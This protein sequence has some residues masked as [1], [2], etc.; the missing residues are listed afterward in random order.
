M[1]KFYA[2][3]FAAVAWMGFAACS[4]D[5]TTDEVAPEVE[6][7]QVTMVEFFAQADNVRTE[8]DD[9]Q[10][11]KW[12]KED[13]IS[14]FDGENKE[15]KVKDYTDPYNVSFEGEL[16]KGE[17]YMALYPHTA[18]ATA[19]VK[20]CT[21]SNV[22]VPAAQTLT[23]GTFAEG[24]AVAVAYTTDNTLSFKN[25]V[26][27]LKFQVA[28]ACETITITS[29]EPLAGTIDVTYDGQNEPTI[30]V[31]KAEYT[32]TLTGPFAAGQTYYA[33]VLPG[34]SNATYEVRFN[35]YLSTKKT[36]GKP[37]QRSVMMNMQSLPAPEQ[38][39]WYVIGGMNKWTLSDVNYKMYKDNNGILVLR[40][41]NVK[42]QS[43]QTAGFQFNK[44]S[45]SVQ[46]GAYATT[47][48]NFESIGWYGAT[49]NKDHKQNI[50]VNDTSVPYD[51]Y[52]NLY[53]G[54]TTG[55]SCNFIAVKSSY[56]S[57]PNQ[58]S[59]IGQVEGTDWNKDFTLVKTSNTTAELKNIQL[60][61]EF[62]VRL[63]SNWH[64]SWAKTGNGVTLSNGN[65]KVSTPGRYDVK[66][67]FSN[68]NNSTQVNTVTRVDV[69]KVD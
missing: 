28:T 2:Y 7:G 36:A 57:T 11:T 3:L 69:T 9:A 26:S 43:G 16:T 35:G 41:V 51:I 54:T 22:E 44:G 49:Y 32:L 67:T 31:K 21:I 65:M 4:E 66:V 5:A 10:K 52:L 62:K 40:N 39:D 29:D 18:T 56:N 37:R 1:K 64:T 14:L 59:L 68:K 38:S 25:V 8:L 45:W 48:N 30:S 6:N 13:L 12:H 63:E 27:I 42:N 20:N 23:A 60:D 17:A 15:F 24:A 58:L 61:G 50:N 55:A 33:T 46:I 34:A 53:G 47:A 19:D